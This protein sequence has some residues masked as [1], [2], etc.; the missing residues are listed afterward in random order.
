MKTPA[1]YPLSKLHLWRNV[2]IGIAALLTLVLIDNRF[3]FVADHVPNIFFWDQW[4]IYTPLFNHEN[5]WGMFSYQHGPHRQGIGFLFTAGLAWLTDWD[6]RGDAF[7]TLGATITAA[8][9]A[10]RLATRC[11]ARTGVFLVTIPV[12]F[13]SLRQYEAW[14]GPA[15]PSHGAFPI[16]LMMLLCLAWFIRSAL[17]RLTLI[18][19]LSFFLTFTGFGLFIAALVPVVLGLETWHH[20]SAGH[21]RSY[22][23][24]LGA[25]VLVLVGWGLF[26]LHY[27]DQPAVDNFRF[28][29]EKPWEYAYFVCLMLANF[30][31]LKGN[32]G[33]ALTG[34]AIL[35]GLLAA[36]ATEQGWKLVKSQGHA[37]PAT[38]TLFLLSSATLLFC[39]NTAI[40]RVMLG[41]QFAPYASRYVTLL[42]PGIFALYLRI[43]QVESNR[44]RNLGWAALLF[45]SGWHGLLLTTQE[46]S[47]AERYYHGR[48]LWKES[49]LATGS[50]QKADAAT[51]K[52]LGFVIYPGDLSARL[53]YLRQRDLNLFKPSPP[54]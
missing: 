18:T 7:L 20:H 12:C 3:R 21:R 11:R 34:G 25:M 52:A 19:I 27:K 8:L 53:E 49:Y 48:L 16:L 26:F 30:V 38:T 40:G 29:Y 36:L 54:F 28:P 41:W 24:T 37:R 23:L 14:V 39:L 44:W 31:G 45:A 15:N 17:P 32:I 10:F 42:I 9:F 22:W 5:V 43:E 33:L 35:V 47:S 50:Q 1:Q 6:A 4:D 46:Q 13:L 2:G 51:E